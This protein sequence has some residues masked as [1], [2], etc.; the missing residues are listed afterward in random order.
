MYFPYLRGRQFEAI[1][2]RELLERGLISKDVIPII[3]P[4]KLSSTL[5]K[6]MS[7]YIEKDRKIVIVHN[8]IVGSFLKDLEEAKKADMVKKYREIFRDERIIKG[9]ITNENSSKDLESLVQSGVS[10]NDMVS[11][12]FKRDVLEQYRT[13]FSE[14][15][16]MYNLIPDDRKFGR[17]AKNNK[18]LF[19]DRYRKRPRNVD[20]LGIDEFYSD[21][22]LYFKDE[23]YKGYSDFSIVGEEYS[24]SGFAPYSVAIHIVYFNKDQELNVKHFVSDSNEDIRDPG[25]KFYEAVSKLYKWELGKK[26]S[27]YGYN[28]LLKH[29]ENQTYPGLGVVKKLCIMHHI[30]L[31]S[32][33]FEEAL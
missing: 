25:G 2:V 16:C 33:L 7:R 15:I 6:T 17:V 29:Y 12:S 28:E 3:E 23:G 20:Y 31:I 19:V 18:I 27:T 26:I 24:E 9:H 1:A 10:I 30:E 32:Q 21:D 11:I 4:V 8:P 13:I 22:H 14:K 5:I